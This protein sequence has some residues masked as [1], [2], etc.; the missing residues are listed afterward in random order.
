MVD[1]KALLAKIIKHLN[2]RTVTVTAT[3]ATSIASNSAAWIK[4]PLPSNGTAIAIV[5][6]YLSGGFT[7]S[8]Y[9]IELLSDGAMFALRNY[10]S[11]ARS[12]TISARYLVVD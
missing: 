5:G 9:S 3:S 10:D 1:V 2:F 4:V 7:C 8:I 11:A 12:V 6:Y